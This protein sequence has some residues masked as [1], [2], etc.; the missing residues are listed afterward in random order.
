[1]PTADT[2]ARLRS[3]RGGRITASKIILG[4]MTSS[5]LIDTFTT[6]KAIDKGISHSPVKS[7][8]ASLITK[9]YIRSTPF[10]RKKMLEGISRTIVK[11][12]ANE[13]PVTQ[14]MISKLR[15]TLG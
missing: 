12:N 14:E 4:K 8:K 13:N 5:E 3:R 6:L 1:M 9:E 15:K 7:V 11:R 2:T 10:E